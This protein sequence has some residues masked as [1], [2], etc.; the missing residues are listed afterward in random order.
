MNT[1]QHRFVYWLAAL[2]FMLGAAVQVEAQGRKKNPTSK[3]YVADVEGDA[4]I[5]TGETID[6]LTKRSV[7]TAQGTIIETKP[8][9]T[10]ALVFSN[11][12]GIYFDPDTRV[13]VRKFVQEPFTP[14]RSD[15][16][17]EPSI[18]TTQAYLPRGTVGLCTSKM[19]AGS[20][21]R[22]TTP[23]ASIRVNARKLVIETN[24]EGTTISAIEGSATV[25]SGTL[26]VGGHTIET[27]QQIFVP[28][29]GGAPQIG[30]IPREKMATLDD[31]V[32]I[33]CMARKTVYFETAEGKEEKEASLNGEEITAFDEA[34]DE[35]DEIVAVETTPEEI[36]VQLT[37]SAAKLP[38][39]E[40][41]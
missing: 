25:Q 12:A 32:A 13:E 10:N 19:V 24:S 16:E 7:Y 30:P 6:P 29:S 37:V 5:D 31:K 27:G 2:A 26:D 28:A 34:E 23:H 4:Q 8:D 35:G 41:K 11:G 3:L 33:A 40:T 21:M 36:P 20:S 1:S 39:A 22:Y 38:P 9:A 17:V 14:N 15:M 18:S